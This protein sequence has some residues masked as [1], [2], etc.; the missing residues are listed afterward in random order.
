MG[1][2]YKMEDINF[3]EKD[4]VLQLEEDGDLE[5]WEAGFML[6]ALS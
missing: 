4:C 5:G 6:G 2:S 1:F 3:Y